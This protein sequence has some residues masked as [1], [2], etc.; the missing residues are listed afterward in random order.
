MEMAKAKS[1]KAGMAPRESQS[2][3]RDALSPRGTW[4]FCSCNAVKR[5][6]RRLGQLYDDALAPSGLRGTQFG[7]LTQ[8]HYAEGPRLKALAEMLVMDLSALGHTLQPLIRDGLVELRV[9]P[10]D[11]RAKRAYLTPAGRAALAKAEPLWRQAQ[12]RFEAL[13]GKSGTAELLEKM[14]AIAAPDFA[15]RFES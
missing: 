3:G 15:E 7:L 11:R 4:Q 9:A 10:E 6:S 12:N 5:A 2:G 8:I 1:A 14:A 13:Y